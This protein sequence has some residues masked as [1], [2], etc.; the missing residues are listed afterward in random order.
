MSL[1][2]EGRRIIITGV[3]GTNGLA[4]AEKAVEYGATVVGFSRRWKEEYTEQINNAGPGTFTW[5]KCDVTK[6]EMVQECVDKAAELMGGIDATVCTP[7]LYWD[8]PILYL[9]KEDFDQMFATCFYGTV[10]MNQCCFPYLKESQGT[11]I[12]FGSGAGV[13][14]KV[15]SIAPAHYSA[16]KG[17]VHAWTKK[18]AAEWGQYGIT[19]NV[20]NPMVWANESYNSLNTPQKLAWFEGRINQNL[21]I[22]QV[23]LERPGAKVLIAPYVCFLCSKE[24]KYITGQ[25]LN[26]DGGMVESR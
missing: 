7:L 9:T 25:I 20:F 12:N 17:A 15:V 8:K 4:F 3:S 22:P 19:A 14:S 5:M 23:Y 2:L 6:K 10:Y 18:L 11:I 24:A 13:T 16:A 1:M 26:C 21:Y